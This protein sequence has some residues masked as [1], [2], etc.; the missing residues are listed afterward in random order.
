MINPKPIL[1]LS[2]VLIGFMISIS[3]S[4]LD[5]LGPNI[6]LPRKSIS[7]ILKTSD[8][9]SLLLNKENKVAKS[10]RKF[11][12]LYLS[13]ETLVHKHSNLNFNKNLSDPEKGIITFFTTV[14][15]GKSEDDCIYLNTYLRSYD[16]GDSWKIGFLE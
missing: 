12:K 16:Y 15:Y 4:F 8:N 1:A 9:S 13:Q 14:C 11:A 6:P 5:M 2:I 7:E 3:V 10:T